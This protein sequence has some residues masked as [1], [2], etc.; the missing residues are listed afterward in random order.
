MDIK[1]VPRTLMPKHSDWTTGHHLNV[2]ISH[3][4]LILIIFL[5]SRTLPQIINSLPHFC[6]IKHFLGF[7]CIGC[8]VTRGL[9]SMGRLDLVSAFE[10][11]PASVLIIIA[12][13][14]KIPIGLI[15]L[16]DMAKSKT[17]FFVSTK[18]N[19]IVTVSMFVAYLLNLITNL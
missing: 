4:F 19:I 3:T 18:I 13:V 17:L 1:I 5:F 2:I 6:L 8:G 15:A 10:Y 11:N 14:I 7:D 9:I 12:I 16:Q